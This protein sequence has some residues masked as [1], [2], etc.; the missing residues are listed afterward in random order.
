VPN[1]PIF[2]P[3]QAF[4]CPR[5]A[6][7]KGIT[8]SKP[9]R[10]RCRPAPGTSKAAL[11]GHADGV[12]NG[13]AAPPAASRTRAAT[14]PCKQITPQRRIVG[15]SSVLPSC[16]KKVESVQFSDYSSLLY[17]NFVKELNHCSSVV[18]A[19]ANSGPL[20][21]KFKFSQIHHR[22][23]TAK[24]TKMSTQNSAKVARI[25][26]RQARA[27]SAPN[28]FVPATRRPGARFISG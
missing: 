21:E 26:A 4:G 1:I 10:S 2:L 27:L 8:A 5:F 23:R 6:G 19:S 22:R 7:L 25:V 3:L 16:C 17:K 14:A 13:A 18:K 12:D 24:S 28:A 20:P 9:P 15:F 11:P